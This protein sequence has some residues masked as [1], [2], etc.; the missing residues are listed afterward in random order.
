MKK[1][2]LA[3]LFL[4]TFGCLSHAQVFSHVSEKQIMITDVIHNEKPLKPRSVKPVDAYIHFD[5]EE[6]EVN[7]NDDLEKVVVV[8]Q[9]Q[10]GQEV[11]SYCCDTN[12]EPV[13]SLPLPMTDGA[14]T[15][16]IVGDTYEGVGDFHL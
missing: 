14:Y 8:I 6:I 11:C 2:T 13:V 1:I 15:L 4:L 7:F 9:D 10:T 3:V 12:T 16:R 5:F